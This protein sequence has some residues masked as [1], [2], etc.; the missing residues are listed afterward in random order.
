MAEEHVTG[1]TVGDVDGRL[2]G[3]LAF[4]KHD[5]DVC[6]VCGR[7][8]VNDQIGGQNGACYKCVGVGT[9]DA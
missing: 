4:L 1:G 8:V 6:H 2:C 7:L 3:L 5:E 9:T